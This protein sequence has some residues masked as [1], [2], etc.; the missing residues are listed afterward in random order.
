MSSSPDGAGIAIGTRNSVGNSEEVF[1]LS[2]EEDTGLSNANPSENRSTSM[3]VTSL[4]KE[5][6]QVKLFN[7]NAKYNVQ[8]I[9]VYIE[10]T[11]QQNIG[12]LHPVS[13]G[14]ILFKKLKVKNILEIKS[15]G[16]N[17][18]DANNLVRNVYLRS[19]NFKAYIPSQLL[20]IKGVIRGVDTEFDDN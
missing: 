11:N 14:H 4:L 16:R 8:N 3:E 7:S 6:I 17:I 1:T 9:Y 2:D 13:V 12:R 10:K 5:D 20:E 15:I 18:V 19:K